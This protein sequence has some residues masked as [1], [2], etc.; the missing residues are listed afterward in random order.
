MTQTEKWYQSK[1][2][3]GSII[4]VVAL[5]LGMFGYEISVSDQLVITEGII[6]LAG[7]AGGFLAVFGRVT[8]SKKIVK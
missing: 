3:W 8:A 2:I 6:A 5:V 4:A 7:I 1:T